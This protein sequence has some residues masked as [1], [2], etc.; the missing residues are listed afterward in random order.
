ML[1]MNTKK[2]IAMSCKKI[3]RDL[4]VKL[5]KKKLSHDSASLTH[6]IYMFMEEIR[7]Q[8]TMKYKVN[9]STKL[10]FLQNGNNWRI[11]VEDRGVASNVQSN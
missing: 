7:C 10:L 9:P 8:K 3:D 6:R 2:Y 5:E 4:W 1:F 11:H